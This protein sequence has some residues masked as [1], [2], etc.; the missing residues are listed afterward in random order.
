MPVIS[1]VENQPLVT[2]PGLITFSHVKYTHLVTAILIAFGSKNKEH[3]VYEPGELNAIK[4]KC[5]GQQLNL[6]TKDIIKSLKIERHRRGSRGRLRINKRLIEFNSGIHHELLKPLKKVDCNTQ[7]T[8]NSPLLSLATVNV[9][10]PGSKFDM[11]VDFVS[12]IH[13]DITVAWVCF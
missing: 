4:V 2:V 3:I 5:S 13:L 10:S 6:H 1:H 7:P 8:A 9:Q 11:F 12:E